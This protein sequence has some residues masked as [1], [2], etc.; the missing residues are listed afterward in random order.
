MGVNLIH[1]PKLCAGLVL[2]S[3]SQTRGLRGPARGS[4]PSAMALG[5][6]EVDLGSEDE[7]SPKKVAEV[8]IGGHW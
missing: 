3:L 6:G 7:E 5:E 1:P 8:T 4:G 2:E